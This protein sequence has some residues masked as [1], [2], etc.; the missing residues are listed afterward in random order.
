[1]FHINL[2]FKKQVDKNSP[3]TDYV[4]D[5]TARLDIFLNDVFSILC[6]NFL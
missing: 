2:R 1:M 3:I 6:L 5:L 4:Y